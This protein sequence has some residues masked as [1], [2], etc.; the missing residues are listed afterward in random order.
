[1]KTIL[2]A[3][4][5]LVPAGAVRAELDGSVVEPLVAQAQAQKAAAQ[6]RPPAAEATNPSAVGIAGEWRAIEGCHSADGGRQNVA[7]TLHIFA[8]NTAELIVVSYRQSDTSCESGQIGRTV[9]RYEY[10]INGPSAAAPGAFD[11]T[12]TLKSVKVIANNGDV[13]DRTAE[14]GGKVTRNAVKI[15]KDPESGNSLYY[16]STAGELDSSPT[17][18]RAR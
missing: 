9:G 8:D 15:I 2:L 12:W 6:P 16:V 3:V 10:T 13:W 18:V 7:A 14:F 11:T 17:Y 4:L 1:M 5:L